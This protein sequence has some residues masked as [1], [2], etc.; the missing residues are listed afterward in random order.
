MDFSFLGPH[1]VLH[2]NIHSL[3]CLGA[4]KESSVREAF[5][6][7]QPWFHLYLTYEC[8]LHRRP[9][10]R[11]HAKKKMFQP[12]DLFDMRSTSQAYGR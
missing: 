6:W 10:K 8:A 3:S 11:A 2:A 5:C 12:A 4:V 7:L 1:T 9:K